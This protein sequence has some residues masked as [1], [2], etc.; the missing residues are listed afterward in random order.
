MLLSFRVQCGVMHVVI[1]EGIRWDTFAPIA[2]SKP[3]FL[4]RSGMGT[5]LDKQIELL[6]P[7]RLTL[8]VRPQLAELVRVQVVPKLKV[9]AAVNVPL[10]DEPALLATGRTMHFATFEMPEEPAAVVEE[11]ELVRF[12]RVA[13]MS[14]LG[15]DDVLNRSDKWK[16]VLD[17]PRTAPQGRY[18]DRLWDLVA[19]NEESLISDFVHWRGASES[20]HEGPWHLINPDDIRLMKGAKLGAGCV[21]DASRGPI[22]LDVGA[23]VGANA[24]IEGP[25]YIG[26]YSIISP[27]STVRPGTTIG[28]V[29]KVGGEISNSIVSSFSNMPHHGFVGDSCVGSWV[30][31]GAGTT[32]SNLKN[33]YGEVR[34]RIGER[35]IPTG[36][37]WLG[38]MIG[39]H[40]KLAIGTRLNAGSYV[41]YSAQLN[42]SQFPPKFIPSFTFWTDQGME[43]YDV[44]KAIHVAQRMMD[45]RDKPITALDEQIMRYVASAAPEVEK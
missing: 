7:T 28:Y 44:D 22:V 25:C 5:L 19:W 8:W 45:R 39:D 16:R 24:V 30:N 4:L 33:T 38:A 36:L 12:A 11:G 37:R 6:K 15:P 34:M 32:T 41:G 2:L 17:L 23:S 21:L 3:T 13:H 27:Q 9:P 43:R 42:G 18:V 29:C 20:P 1:F 31:L 40:S 14:G 35:E 10:D 26:Q